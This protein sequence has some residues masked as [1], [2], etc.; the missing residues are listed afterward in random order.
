[1]DWKLLNS[2][3]QESEVMEMALLE[4]ISGIKMQHRLEGV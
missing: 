2:F 1:M 3:N 4:S